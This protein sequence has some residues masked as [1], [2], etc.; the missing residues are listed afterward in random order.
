M[1]KA[2]IVGEKSEV[3]LE[4][5]M[6]EVVVE[7][8]TLTQSMFTKF[9]DDPGLIISIVAKAAALAHVDISKIHIV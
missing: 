1:I 8:G 9:K 6:D 3:H 5:T 4:G 2:N 7:Y